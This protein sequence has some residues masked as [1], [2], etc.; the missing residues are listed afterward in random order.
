MI[1]KLVK[2]IIDKYVQDGT[3][4]GD[5]ITAILENNLKETF[6]RGDDFN[7]M[8]LKDIMSYVYWETPANSWGSRERVREW[9][10]KG[11]LIG[12]QA[13]ANDVT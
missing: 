9:Q 4:G 6:I 8:H 13:K 5:F 11:G 7:L 2:D 10:R 12:I 3:D 1:P